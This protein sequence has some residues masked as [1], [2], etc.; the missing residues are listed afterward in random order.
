[1]VENGMNIDKVIDECFREL[2]LSEKDIFYYDMLIII[3]WLSM[4]LVKR[5]RKIKRRISMK[6]KKPC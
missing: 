1:L 2:R 3:Q 6:R 5:R 4:A